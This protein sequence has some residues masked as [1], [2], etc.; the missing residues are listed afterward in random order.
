VPGGAQGWGARAREAWRATGADLPY[1]DPRGH[2]AVP[3]EGYYWRLSDA[4]SGRVVVA[5]C[6]VLGGRGP[7]TAL[8]AMTAHPG[9]AVH[10]A[11]TAGVAADPRG[12]GLR[13]G[14]V[15]RADPELLE[16]D[17]GPGARLSVRL[18]EQRGWPRRA[19][20]GL[21]PAGAL[22]GL[23]QYWHPHL[24]GGRAN[25]DAVVGGRELAMR[26]AAPY[27]EKNWGRRFPP[28]WWWG[29]AQA[30]A[31]DACVAFAGGHALGRRGPAATGVVL[32]VGAR[33]LR[34]VPPL[35]AV[36]VEARDGGR[37]IRAYGASTRLE[38]EVEGGEEPPAR[39]PVPPARPGLPEGQ[40]D[41]H[42]A[43]R[44]RVEL[45]R[46]GRRVWRGESPLAGLELGG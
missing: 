33:V 23:G 27:A 45:R 15:L 40:V 31:E 38:L 22:P 30:F 2:H 7:R 26:G 36:R 10:V 32:R 24:L 8:V 44:L 35:G 3:M 19:F 37:R 9:G 4:R 21:G 1:G 18:R 43:G 17:I 46:R 6:G 20:G 25:V 29:H 28:R 41:Q 42:L 13:A 14:D 16:V 5:L 11:R 39:L 34:L 12:L